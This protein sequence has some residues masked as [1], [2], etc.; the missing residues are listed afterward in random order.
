MEAKVVCL[1]RRRDISSSL[2]SLADSNASEYLHSL[3][4][5]PP[6]DLRTRRVPAGVSPGS[7]PK[8]GHAF[9]GGTCL[10]CGGR[11]VVTCRGWKPGRQ[12]MI[13]KGRM[14]LLCVSERYVIGHEKSFREAGTWGHFGDIGTVVK[15]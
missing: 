12:T 1:F 9:G 5:S 7:T 8:G 4:L 11:P 2:N 10:V 14:W 3:P 6:Q 15:E 13:R